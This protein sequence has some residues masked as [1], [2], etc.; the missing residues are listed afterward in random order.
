MER[1]AM[2]LAIEALRSPL[3]KK[4]SP[5]RGPPRG[6]LTVIKAAAGDETTLAHHADAHGLDQDQVKEAAKHYL[7]PLLLNPENKGL[8]M[9]GL[10]DSASETEFKDHKRWLLKWLHPDR[11]PNTWEQALFLK[12]SST[13]FEVAPK[14]V[15]VD[16]SPPPFPT[17]A[18]GLA[19]P[20]PR[21]RK[22]NP[23]ARAP[24]EVRRRD[25]SARRL[26]FR[27]S[28]PIMASLFLAAA[29]TWMSARIGSQAEPLKFLSSF[30]GG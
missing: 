8:S 26:L 4:R 7:L 16:Q 12:V 18:K 28:K 24:V 15:T 6:M 10:A 21:R 20:H 19:Q 14:S 3:S 25:T 17:A 30:I 11:N 9:I 29:L 23:R 1:E 2:D 22:P 5:L 13:K 27:F